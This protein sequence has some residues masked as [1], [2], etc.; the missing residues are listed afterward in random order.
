MV[1]VYYFVL[2]ENLNS[3]FK[4]INNGTSNTKNIVIGFGKNY[5]IKLIKKIKQLLLIL[6]FSL[7]ICT[8]N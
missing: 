6:P 7:L 1:K 3:L 8:L 2:L 4:S 5:L